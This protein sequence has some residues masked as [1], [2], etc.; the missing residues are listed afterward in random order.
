MTCTPWRCRES[1]LAGEWRD[2]I[3]KTH[4]EREREREG[5]GGGGGG[6]GE[7]GV[8]EELWRQEARKPKSKKK[9]SR[10]EQPWQWGVR[11]TGG[12]D[13]GEEVVER[14]KTGKKRYEMKGMK[15][16]EAERWVKARHP[17]LISLSLSLSLSL[18]ALHIFPE[19]NKGWLT[20]YYQ[21]LFDPD[22]SE[23]DSAGEDVYNSE[24]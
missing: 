7:G 5:G 11:H 15:S 23:A 1:F 17:P 8:V 3:D 22:G 18:S 12:Q 10:E 13:G 20:H 21:S 24:D 9:C 2:R 6:G 14:K 19:L 4:R 16:T